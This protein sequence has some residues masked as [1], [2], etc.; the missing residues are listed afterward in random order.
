MYFRLESI[1][2]AVF[3]PFVQNMTPELVVVLAQDMKIMVQSLRKVR[4][5]WK[6]VAK[7]SGCQWPK[8]SS[9][10]PRTLEVLKHLEHVPGDAE[11]EDE[12]DV[13]QKI[14]NDVGE[15]DELKT[16]WGELPH[17]DDTVEVKIEK[18]RKAVL[19]D[20][21]DKQVLI[22]DSDEARVPCMICV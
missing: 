3:R 15:K 5:G 6:H 22:C 14:W 11:A 8:R 17:S 9:R 20:L 21:K 18:K 2:Y 16:L 19:H 10:Y 13:M 12:A 7:A 4:R 1:A